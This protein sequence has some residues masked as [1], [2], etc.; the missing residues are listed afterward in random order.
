[1]L[2][3]SLKMGINISL[4]VFLFCFVSIF[5][6]DPES[7]QLA[8][9]DSQNLHEQLFSFLL[10]PSKSLASSN[11]LSL[12]NWDTFPFKYP[13][14]QKGNHNPDRFN[15]FTSF[16]SIQYNHLQSSISEGDLGCT[17]TMWLAFQG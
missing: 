4:S 12:S 15:F 9:K 10:F 17:F 1:M 11:P 13:S 7:A 6:T 14:L 5:S 16:S 8:C 3:F 2:L